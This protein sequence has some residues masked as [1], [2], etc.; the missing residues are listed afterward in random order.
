MMV[1]YARVSATD[2]KL[3]AQIDQLEAYGCERI[4]SE[5]FSGR[6]ADARQELLSA[7]SFVRAGDARGNQA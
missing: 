7:M 3:G 4:F 1:G 6:S 5:H 2:Q